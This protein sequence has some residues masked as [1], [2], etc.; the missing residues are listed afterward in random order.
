MQ[1]NTQKSVCIRFGPRFRAMCKSLDSFFGGV[2]KWNNSCRYLGVY[3]VSGRIFTC[4]FCFDH[5]KS[6]FFRSFNAI[7]SKIGRFASEEVVIS[8]IYAK[9]LPVLLYGTQACNILTRDK[10]SREFTVTRSLMKLFKT[11]SAIIVKDCQKIFYLLPVSYLINIR[12]A[13]FLDNFVTNE[14]CVCK[15]LAC[16]AQRNLNK[17]FLSY[18]DDISSSCNLKSYVIEN[19]F[20]WYHKMTLHC[21]RAYNGHCSCASVY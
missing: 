12:M 18:S 3:F 4:C 19:F 9:C 11:S 7:F 13:K 21:K 5:A 10:R 17:L 15:L 2:V 8:L 1:L 6:Q 16:N 20:E 14:N